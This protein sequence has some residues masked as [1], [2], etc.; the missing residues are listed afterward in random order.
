MRIREWSCA[1]W[2]RLPSRDGWHNGHNGRHD[3][4]TTDVGHYSRD[5]TTDAGHYSRDTTTDAGYIDAVAHV[6]HAVAHVGHGAPDALGLVNR[7]LDHDNRRRSVVRDNRVGQL[8]YNSIHKLL[9]VTI[10]S[11][12]KNKSRR[13]FII[14]KSQ[15]KTHTH[16]H[17]CAAVAIAT[18]TTAIIIVNIRGVA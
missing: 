12:I 6:V 9:Q 17:T 14:I 13:S 11:K 10:T 8:V 16:T 7:L 5:T 18:V 15:P 4:N 2:F 1:S 3:H